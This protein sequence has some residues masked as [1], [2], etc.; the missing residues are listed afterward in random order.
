MHIIIFRIIIVRTATAPTITAAAAAAAAVAGA[1]AT[2]ATAT[3]AHQSLLNVAINNGYTRHLRMSHGLNTL[4]LVQ[5]RRTYDVFKPV[6][7]MMQRCPRPPKG[8]PYQMSQG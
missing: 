5:T 2:T 1:T 6:G 4:V 3:R 8:V 7:R